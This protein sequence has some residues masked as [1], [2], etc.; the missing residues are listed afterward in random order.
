MRNR[1]NKNDE[2]IKEVKTEEI[3]ESELDNLEQANGGSCIEIPVRGK[4]DP[5]HSDALEKCPYCNMPTLSLYNVCNGKLIRI[6]VN[7]RREKC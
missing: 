3:K 7:C 1:M 5:V 4:D 6:C 2:N